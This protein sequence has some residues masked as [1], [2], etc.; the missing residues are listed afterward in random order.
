MY[1]PTLSLS[2]DSIWKGMDIN[3]YSNPYW[4]WGKGR[5]E[6]LSRPLSY[7]VD[8]QSQSSVFPVLDQ[9]QYYAF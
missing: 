9:F 1:L 3:K 8:G 6:Y 5:K 2:I 4:L 7:K